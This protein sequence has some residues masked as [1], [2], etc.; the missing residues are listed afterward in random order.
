MA[1]TKILFLTSNEYGQS[2]VVLATAHALLARHCAVHIASYEAPLIA[3]RV[4]LII[5][6]G[7]YRSTIRTRVSDLSAGAYGA[8]PKGAIPAVFHAI[9]SP[10]MVERLALDTSDQQAMVHGPGVRECLRMFPKIPDVLA[11]WSP[12]EYVNG[13]EGFREVLRRVDADVVV[14]EKLCAQ[15]VDACRAEG[16]KIVL[17]TPNSLKE[18]VAQVQPNGFALWGIPIQV[19]GFPYPLPW[20]LIPINI[21]LFIRMIF[22]IAFSP[23]LK[24]L[25]AAR[26]A[27][28]LPG[29]Y[30]IFVPYS[31]DVQYILPTA[32]EI[33]FKFPYIPPNITT[34][35]PILLP[36]Y[37][38]EKIEPDLFSWLKR[39]PTVLVNLGSHYNGSKDFNRGLAKAIRL[40]V[41]EVPNIQVLWKLKPSREGVDPHLGAILNPVDSHVKIVDWLKAE[42]TSLLCSGHIIAS[43]HHGG[44]NAYFESI[45]AGVP[46]VVLPC[47][48]D[49]FDYAQKVEYLGIGVWGSRESAPELDEEECGKA[50]IKAVVDE[51]MRRKAKELGEFIRNK[52]RGREEAADRILE[53]AKKEW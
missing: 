38:L 11:A 32:M 46:Q 26:K 4:Q 24:G 14:V 37:P 53:L 21:L 15:G 52:Y 30:P 5:D 29:M 13:V 40:L 12:E 48:F 20:Y 39:K 41:N 49:T 1:P 35:G 31:K 43:L 25:E 50:L 44:A 42:P 7:N 28:N 10:G 27:A 19:S 23:K 18:T 22:V 6:A 2:N 16:K 17:I 51:D 33:D 36:S 3:S 47:W 9:D 45:Y 34:C 8:L